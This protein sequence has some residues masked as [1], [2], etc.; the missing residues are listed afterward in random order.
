MFTCRQHNLFGCASIG[1][2]FN[3]GSVNIKT[4]PLSIFRCRYRY[5]DL[6]DGYHHAGWQSERIQYV[7][8]P[9]TCLSNPVD[10]ESTGLSAANN[11][12]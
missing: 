9:A 4:V 10:S 5:M 7:W 8:L 6:L 12:I 11:R 1:K 2:C 3:T